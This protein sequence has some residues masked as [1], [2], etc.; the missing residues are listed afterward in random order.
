MYREV[1]DNGIDNLFPLYPCHRVT[2][3]LNYCLNS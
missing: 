1:G 3:F 2:C